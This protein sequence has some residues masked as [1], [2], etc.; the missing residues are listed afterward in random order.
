MPVLPNLIERALYRTGLAPRPVIDIA[1]AASFRALQ[2][3]LRLDVFERLAAR[4]RTAA[5][6]AAELGVDATSLDRLLGL[7]E[8]AGHV[9]R[10]RDVYANSASTKRWLLARSAGTLKDFIGMW[11]DVV[12]DEWDTLEDSIRGGKPAEHMHDWLAA[13]ESGRRSTPR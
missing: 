5:D 9:V 1:A 6:L 10:D 11:T 2:A 7:L 3:G 13:A 4:P 8:A 12:F